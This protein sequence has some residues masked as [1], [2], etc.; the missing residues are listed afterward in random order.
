MIDDRKGSR[1]ARFGLA[2]R[3]ALVAAAFIAIASPQ[4][5]NGLELHA[6]IAQ[7]TCGEPGL[8]PCPLQRFMRQQVAAPLARGDMKMI[9]ASLRRVAALAPSEMTSWSSIASQG[10]AAADQDDTKSLRATCSACHEAYRAA[11][12]AK[13]RARPIGG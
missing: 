1:L 5:A 8:A 7:A 9:A 11:Y 3:F 2:L 12:R 13:Y 10:A 4:R 6:R